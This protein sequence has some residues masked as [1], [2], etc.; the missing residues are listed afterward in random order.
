MITNSLDV[1]LWQDVD[2]IK[3]YWCLPEV[4]VDVKALLEIRHRYLDCESYY[5][6]EER[7]IAI[8]R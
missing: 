2:K 7:L 5:Y 6:K 3:N 8:D 1:L 4:K